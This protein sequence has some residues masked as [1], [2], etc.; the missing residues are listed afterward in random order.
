MMSQPLVMDSVGLLP[1]NP[2]A[3]SFGPNPGPSYL[4]LLDNIEAIFQYWY[5][6]LKV[7]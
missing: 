1:W 6:L 3:D 7:S 2:A 5:F 4:I